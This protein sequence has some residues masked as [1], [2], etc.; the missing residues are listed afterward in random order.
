[1][2]EQIKADDETTL[3]PDIEVDGDKKAD[4]IIHISQIE[5][6]ST[7]QNIEPD[8]ERHEKEKM[9]TDYQNLYTELMKI[10][11][12]IEKDYQYC[13]R[14]IEF[15]LGTNIIFAITFFIYFMNPKN[16]KY[17]P[18]VF[19]GELLFLFNAFCF[20]YGV[21]GIS[22]KCP[23]KTLKFLRLIY[24][25]LF[26][27]LCLTAW[28]FSRREEVGMI[29]SLFGTISTLTVLVTGR[30][31]TLYFQRRRNICKLLQPIAQKYSLTFDINAQ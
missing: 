12:L 3:P 29:L 22:K 23:D 6:S 14:W 8:V 1:M 21:V 24:V 5:I 19:L 25:D 31:I 15:C 26:I 10:N 11:S 17:E 9:M 16:H 4:E 2:S 18:I 27:S 30:G 7:E 13:I 28:L 20:S